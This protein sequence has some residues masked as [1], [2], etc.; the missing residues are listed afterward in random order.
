MSVVASVRDYDSLW[1]NEISHVVELGVVAP[2]RNYDSL[3]TVSLSNV[4]SR[5]LLQLY[6]IT[7]ACGQNYDSL[8]DSKPVK[9][10]DLGVA[11]VQN[12]NSFWAKF[13]TKAFGQ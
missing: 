11:M 9:C 8:L 4:V 13:V 10:C 3:W 2:V 12:Y 1:T 5:V 7:I 6:E